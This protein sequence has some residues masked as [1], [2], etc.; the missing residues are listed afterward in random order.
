MKEVVVIATNNGA[1]HLARLF[2]SLEKYGCPFEIVIVDTGSTDPESLDFIESIKFSHGATVLHCPGGY[3]T[4]A[5]LHAYRNVQADRYFFF[6]DSIEV[7]KERWWEDFR[8]RM[9]TAHTVVPWLT[10]DFFWDSSEQGQYIKNAMGMSFGD[11][12]PD[13]GIFGPIFYC[14]VNTLRIMETFGNLPTPP[15]SKIEEQGWER[16]WAVAFQAVKAKVNPIQHGFNV[17]KLDGDEYETLR[18][19]RPGR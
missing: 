15:S 16:G 10:F 7:K 17:F 13:A 19:Y 5:Y 14:T 11:N 1:Q 6:H 9:D 18:K 12:L 2:D 3:A 8:E 4:G